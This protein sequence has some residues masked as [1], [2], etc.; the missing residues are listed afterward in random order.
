MS[1]DI[2]TIWKFELQLVGPTALEVKEGAK[3]VHV[4]VDPEGKPCV[5]IELDPSS[6]Q[7]ATLELAIFGTGHP[8]PDAVSHHVGSFM[9][10]GRFMWHV[11]QL[12]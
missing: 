6:G 11:Y 10:A 3:V 2:R 1:D 12:R 4:G 9:E 8:I 7:S 5:W